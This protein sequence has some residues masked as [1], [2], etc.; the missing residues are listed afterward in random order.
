[1]GPRSGP[2]ADTVWPVWVRVLGTSQVALGDD[3]DAVVDVGA[4]KPRSVVAALAMR[5]GSDATLL[6]L[7][8]GELVPFPELLEE[9]LAIT[10]DDAVALDCLAETEHARAL[11]K[12]GTSAHQQVDVYQTARSQG[13]TDSEALSAVVGWLARKTSGT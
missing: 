12:R 7:A 3:P 10:H 8:R 1:M 4:R 13:A 6:D 5:L 2:A 9:L 11:I